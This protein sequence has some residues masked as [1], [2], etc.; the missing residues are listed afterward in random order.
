MSVSA[1]IPAAGTGERMGLKKQFIEL[2]GRP[3]I[4]Y[5]LLPFEESEL[6]DD[7]ILVVGIDD[8]DRIK[9]LIE[10]SGFKKVKKIII[11]G[12]ERQDSVYNG[13]KAI[14]SSCKYVLIHDGA[15]PLVTREIISSVATE[16]N[17]HKA[18]VVGIPS[19]DTVKSVSDEGFIKETLDRGSVWLIQTPQIFS[20]DIIKKAY[21]RAFKIGYIAT[22]DSRL[23]ERLGQKVK[24]VKGSYENIKVTTPED[25][26]FAEAILRKRQGTGDLSRIIGRRSPVTG[27][28]SIKGD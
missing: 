19:K 21:E 14:S 15:R 17:L 6:I 13:I 10:Q 12:K 26:V 2:L 23:V 7:V 1:I 3:L 25:I 5:T 9:K 27:P 4:Y 20:Y 11:G 18:V 16:V 8:T 28:R 24:I 22:D